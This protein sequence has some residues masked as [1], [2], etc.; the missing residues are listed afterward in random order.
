M[1]SASSKQLSN[2]LTEHRRGGFS[3]INGIVNVS[4]PSYQSLKGMMHGFIDLIFEHQG[5][6]F[7]CD[8]KSSHLGDQF[9]D[10]NAVNLK[11]NIEKHYYDLQYLIYCLALHRHLKHSL[12]NYDPK[13]HF[14]GIYYFYLRGMTDEVAHQ[15]RGIYFRKITVEEL[16]KLDVIFM[17]KNTSVVK[18]VMEDSN[19]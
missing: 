10:Y 18:R 11:E 12:E 16:E 17:G 4:L 3:S 1:E 9:E 2:M 8:Y 7:V 14:G 6:F 19:E 5:K 13:L 15:G